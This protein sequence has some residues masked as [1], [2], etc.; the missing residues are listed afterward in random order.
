M[1]AHAASAQDHPDKYRKWIVA[2]MLI[3]AIVLGGG[4]SPQPLTELL[5]QLATVLAIGLWLWLP[6]RGSAGMGWSW[7]IVAALVAVPLLQLIPL[8]PAVWQG[9]PG[10]QGAIGALELV[11]Y[12]DSWRPVSL[13]PG[14]TLAGLLALLPPAFVLVAVSQL[15]PEARLFAIR[16]LLAAILAG[17]LLGAVQ[18]GMGQQ[19]PVLYSASNKGWLIGFQANRNAQSDVILCG[20]ILLA[21]AAGS[22]LAPRG[23]RDTTGLP[24]NA[25]GF[26]IC[27]AILLLALAVV[28]TG[29]RMGIALIP[30]A[31]VGA[32]P[33]LRDHL[34]R[35]G[36]AR[37]VLPVAALA[38]V[39]AVALSLM[40]SP[41]SGIGRVTQRFAVSGDFRSEL[42]E[43]TIFAIGQYW[44]AGF[45]LGGFR[46]AMLPAER[47]EVL[48]PTLPNRAHNEYLEMLLE[49]GLLSV[50]QV[51]A[52]VAIVAMAA[53]RVWRGRGA[54]PLA[55][56]QA[57]AGLAIIAVL[58]LHS[59]VD[60][61]LRCMSLACIAALATGLVMAGSRSAAAAH[62]EG[63]QGDA[64]EPS[65]S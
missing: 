55:D 27:G 23:R 12:Q 2:A 33:L 47:L 54:E 14:Q 35:R 22:Q 59:V 36:R 4:G 45:G 51:L 25:G 15:Q 49:G 6:G 53:T 65:N 43:D 21:L 20:M 13:S 31:F 17:V 40:V 24:G 11:G 48:D 10:R 52:I 5:L 56:R 34:P 63:L 29:S 9:L 38:G 28:L 37:L 39:L 64:R 30:V 50:A 18:V 7:L 46:S 26:A 8:P 1:A 44:P 42:W 16:A 19:A 32:F 62:A 61:P 60:Y 3:L 58:G 41:A 57:I